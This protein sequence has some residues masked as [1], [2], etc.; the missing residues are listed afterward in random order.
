MLGNVLA[1]NEDVDEYQI[2]ALDSL[3]K[4]MPRRIVADEDYYVDIIKSTFYVEES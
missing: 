4:V 2:A 3:A 1:L